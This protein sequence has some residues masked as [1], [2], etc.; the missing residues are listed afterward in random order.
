MGP[1][2][3]MAGLFILTSLISQFISNTATTVLVALIAMS[4]TEGL[5]V[6]PYPFLMTVAIAASTAFATPVAS[7]INTLVLGPGGYRLTDFIK[8]GVP[9]QLMIM[10]LVLLVFPL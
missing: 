8:V 6:S 9:L 2:A 3:V 10:I 5:G 7:P 4:A 1:T